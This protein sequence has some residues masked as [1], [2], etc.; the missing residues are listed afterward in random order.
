MNVFQNK[1]MNMTLIILIAICLLGSTAFVLYQYFMADT[2]QTATEEKPEKLTA[3]E[4][5]E[6]TVETKEIRTNLA[7]NKYILIKFA[8]LMD[9]IEAKSELDKLSIQLNSILVSVL[10]STHSNDIQGAE[11]LQKLETMVLN[12]VNEILEE[13]KVVQVYIPEKIIQ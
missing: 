8:F 11:G 10:A 3:D 7:D 12:R 6:R 2:K 5:L 9:S 1:L 13:G 4:Q